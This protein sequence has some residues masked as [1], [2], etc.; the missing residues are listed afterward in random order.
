MHIRWKKKYP[1]DAIVN[2]LNVNAVFIS[3]D[4]QV[5]SR[6]WRNELKPGNYNKPAKHMA[7]FDREG[8]ILRG[9]SFSQ[10]P[11]SSFG[12]VNFIFWSGFLPSLNNVALK[13]HFVATTVTFSMLNRV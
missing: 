7:K 5:E 13:N 3:E 1:L 4:M 9:L 10:V 8:W 6:E 2:T 12:E 11:Q